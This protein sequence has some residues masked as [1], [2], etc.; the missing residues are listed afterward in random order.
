[1]IQKVLQQNKILFV[2]VYP[3]ILTASMYAAFQ[4]LI[5][6]LGFQ[7]GYIAAFALYWVG[8]GI[9]FPIFVLGGP[10]AI[11]DLFKIPK[12]RKK[13]EEELEEQPSWEKK[14]I[15]SILL[16]LPLIFPASFSFAPRIG[17]AT[18]Q[19]ILISIGIGIAIGTTEEILWRGI[20]IKKFPYSKLLGIIFP[21]IWFAVWHISPQSIKPNPLP[22]GAASFVF[23]ALM[24]GLS[25]GYVAWKTGTI[26]GVATAHVV[27]DSLGLSGFTFLDG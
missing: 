10:K 5:S 21:A 27:H 13:E 14:V 15:L 3:T 20:Y 8:W 24:L 22:G 4:I 2:I 16:W 9:V 19:I 6:E 23:Y 26:R 1:M 7:T 25:W 12:A 18:V 17:D 11:V